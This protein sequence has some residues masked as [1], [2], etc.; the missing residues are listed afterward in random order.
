MKFAEV[1][2]VGGRWAFE[3]YLQK[4]YQYSFFCSIYQHLMKKFHELITKKLDSFTKILISIV[5]D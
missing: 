5:F 1:C 3:Q 2:T 4:N